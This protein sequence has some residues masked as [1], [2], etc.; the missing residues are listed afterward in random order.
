MPTA[1]KGVKLQ[2]CGIILDKDII[3]IKLIGKK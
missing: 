2:G 1:I 3:K